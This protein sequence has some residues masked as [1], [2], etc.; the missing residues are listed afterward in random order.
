MTIETLPG[1]KWFCSKC[2]GNTKKPFHCLCGDHQRAI[3]AKVNW[4]DYVMVSHTDE[5]FSWERIEV[6]ERDLSI[7]RRHIAALQERSTKV[8]DDVQ[9]ESDS[10]GIVAIGN[11]EANF[12][13]PNIRERGEATLRIGGLLFAISASLTCGEPFLQIEAIGDPDENS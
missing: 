1:G 13:F 12:R 11:T 8:V 7:A 5:P 10:E 2:C 9:V 3:L 4:D 6:L